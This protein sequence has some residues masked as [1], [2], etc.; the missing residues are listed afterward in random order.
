[1][2][3]FGRTLSI[4]TA[5]LALAVLPAFAGNPPQS[6]AQE[7]SIEKPKVFL[8]A[9]A[10]DLVQRAI[11]N[12]LKNT[13]RQQY[14]TWKERDVK[15]R[16]TS[17]RQLVE[18]PGGVLG[19]TIEKDGKPLSPD[20]RQKEDDRV[21]RLLNPDEMKAK[22]KEQKEDEERTLKM[23][24]AIPDAFIFT[25]AENSKAANGDNLVHIRFTP[26]PDFDPPSRECLVFE[27]MQGDMMVDVTQT[28][29]AKIDGTLFK[30]VTIG[31]GI[32]GR[33]DKGGRFVVEQQEVYKDHWDQTHMIL[34]FTGKALLFK[35]VKIQEESTA[36]DFHP[37][38]KMDVRTALAFLKSKE[39]V[40]GSTTA[41][42]GK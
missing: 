4:C 31:W 3:L 24:H 18:T 41:E 5:A 33:L 34:N 19:R 28:Q 20:E 21:N 42:A 37:V 39:I 6:R 29:L 2:N 30:D 14:S 17:V 15:P 32:L 38:E 16:G 1:M 7:P 11:E 13:T 25:Y 23:L 8:P 22:W 9:N 36:W 35:T 12:Q 26:N 40:A 10:R 27:G